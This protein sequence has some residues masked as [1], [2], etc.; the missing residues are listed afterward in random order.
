V[1][2]ARASLLQLGFTDEAIA[3]FTSKDPTYVML[4]VALDETKEVL[5]FK[6]AAAL[7]FDALRAFT[8]VSMRSARDTDFGIQVVGR[9]LRAHQFFQRHNLPLRFLL[10]RP[11]YV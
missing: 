10:I 11:D 3:S 8:L 1:P 4:E 9:I 2:H 5:I 7:G 6:M